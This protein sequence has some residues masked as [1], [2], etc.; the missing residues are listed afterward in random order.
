MDKI[1]ITGGQKLE[2][3]IPIS[4][5]KNAALP[6]LAATLL[7]KGDSHLTHVPDLKDVTTILKLLRRLGVTVQ[8]DGN[9]LT[10]NTRTLT[11]HDAPYELVKTMRAAILVLGPLL[12]RLGEAE[13]SL[14]GGCAIGARPI[15]LHLMGLEKMGC[16]IEIRN[17]YVHARLR[18][19][20]AKNSKRL[21]GA[22]I[23]MDTPTV[24]GT[25][26]LMM[27][28]T[29]AEGTT[30]L[31]NAAREPEVV[32][33]A[34]F[35]CSMGARINGAG[36]DI[37]TIEGVQELKPRDYRIMPDRI[38]AGTYMVAGAIT[39]GDIYIKHC[40]PKHLEAVIFKLKEAGV[41][42]MEDVDGLRVKGLDRPK[43]V[44]VKTLPYP[45]FPTDM[46]AQMMALMSMGTGRCVITETI[47]EGR[48]THVGELRRM[49][50]DIKIQGSSAIIQGVPRL[51]GAPVMASDLR[52]SACLILAG[53]AA[54]GETQVLR[55]YHL[56]RGY[57]RIEAKLQKVGAKII[58]SKGEL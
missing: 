6:I 15:N 45:G 24:T 22:R 23:Y 21:H 31:E 4:G 53:L 19:G 41:Q 47:F 11:S 49:G 16:E 17:G 10:L 51:L 32:D 7:G 35:L 39:G 34:H 56:D 37:I 40:I 44:D 38:E 9:G 52:A 57:E 12:A 14:P 28:A 48:F 29:L 30:I 27:A 26:N 43:P 5:S 25:E 3:E 20:P 58:R 50:A 8:E 33:L 1:I 18:E 42:I 54:E 13:V 36:T 55:V 2:G 46:Q